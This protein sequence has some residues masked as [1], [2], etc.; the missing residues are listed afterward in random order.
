MYVPPGCNPVVI[1][2]KVHQNPWRN[3]M[4]TSF[5]PAPRSKLFE[6]IHANERHRKERR[7]TANVWPSGSTP[8]KCSKPSG[9]VLG[10]SE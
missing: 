5:V 2:F 6:Q 9:C 10:S 4:R 1:N 3:F 7:T 8:S